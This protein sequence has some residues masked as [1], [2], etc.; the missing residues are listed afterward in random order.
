[1]AKLDEAVASEL[2]KLLLYSTNGVQGILLSSHD[3]AKSTTA[4][5]CMVL[6]PGSLTVDQLDKYDEN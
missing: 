4:Q 3:D 5:D 2:M 1:V 6:H